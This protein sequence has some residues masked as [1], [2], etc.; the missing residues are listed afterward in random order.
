MEI[1]KYLLEK[2][3]NPAVKGFDYIVKAIE[4]FNED[5]K[6]KHNIMSEL[7]P[8]IAKTFN[9]D[10]SKVE[11]AIRHCIKSARINMQNSEFIATAQIETK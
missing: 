3:L 4:L 7:Y 9:D 2:G 5:I 11:R 10:A 1:E 8:T 6:Y